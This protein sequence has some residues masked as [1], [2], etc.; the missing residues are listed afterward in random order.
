MPGKGLSILV[1]LCRMSTAIAAVL[2][3]VRGHCTMVERKIELRRRRARRKKLIKLR[4]KL[5]TAKEGKE[6]HTVLRMMHIIGPWWR[7]WL[8][9]ALCNQ[10]LRYPGL[11]AS[12]SAPPP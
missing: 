2:W 1:S 3:N 4:D 12:S 10:H 7:V 8:E 6:K 9:W 11:E 5:A